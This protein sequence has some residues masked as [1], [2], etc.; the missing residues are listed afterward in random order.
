MRPKTASA[1][2]ISS[3]PSAA[4]N[5]ARMAVLWES[6]CVVDSRFIC[7]ALSAIA[8]GSSPAATR[9]TTSRQDRTRASRPAAAPQRAVPA[10]AVT[11][12]DSRSKTSACASLVAVKRAPVVAGPRATLPPVQSTSIAGT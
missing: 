6:A 9:A 2:A 11:A 1:T 12:A 8:S 4:L 7:A 5:C 10:T 3:L